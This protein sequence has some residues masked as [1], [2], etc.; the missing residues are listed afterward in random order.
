MTSSLARVAILPGAELRNFTVDLARILHDRFGSEIH[1]YAASPQRAAEYQLKAGAFAASIDPGGSII[2][3]AVPLSRD[4]KAI[5]TEARAFESLLGR[6][7][8][9]L[10]VGHRHFGRGYALAGFHHP[11]SY[12]SEGTSYLQMLETYNELFR[13]WRREIEDKKFTLFIGGTPEAISVFRAHGIP[14]RFMLGSRVKNYH[15]WAHDEHFGNPAVA[16]AYDAC[17][18]PQI[19]P[20]ISRPYDLELTHR[21]IFLAHQGYLGLTKRLALRA[22][23]RLYWKIRGFEKARGYYAGDEL[24]FEYRRWRDTRKMTHRSTC[25]LSDIAGRRFV[26]FPLH[27]EPEA[28]VGMASPEYFYQ[29]AAIAALSRDL[30]AGVLLAVKETI[31]GV[32]RRPDNF[33]DQVR[34]LKNVVLLNMLEFGLDVVKQAAATAT[35]TGTAGFEAAIMGKPVITFGRHNVYNVLPHVHVVRDEAI[36]KDDLAHALSEDFD[37]VTARE[38]GQRYLQAVIDTSFD[39]GPYDY[40]DL[41]KYGPEQVEAALA[42]LVADLLDEPEDQAAAVQEAGMACP[43]P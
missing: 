30:P 41:S 37:S 24:A 3:D 25:R 16:K 7:Y 39:M 29:H 33:Y 36:L 21:G 34:S 26:F 11:R 31:H 42:A 12:L 40:M 6:T 2:L 5:E 38:N 18:E 9:S 35:I 14:C 32:G 13:F 10:A 19:D 8:N 20:E 43:T 22:A 27:T 23:R 15:Y 4:R 1:I 28:S 17:R